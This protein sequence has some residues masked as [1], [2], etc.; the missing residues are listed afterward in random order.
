MSQLKKP[1]G[2]DVLTAARQRISLV[3]DR[4]E[5]VCVSFS[6]GKDST[7]LLHLT[8]DEAIRRKRRVGVLF[9]DLEAQYRATIEHAEACF[10]LYREHIDPYWVALPLSLRNA[11]SQYEPKWTCWD[12]E[13]RC[14][15]GAAAQADHRAGRD[16]RLPRVLGGL[17]DRRGD[18]GAGGDGLTGRCSVIRRSHRVQSRKVIHRNIALC[19]TI[20]L[21]MSHIVRYLILMNGGDGAASDQG[22]TR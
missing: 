20:S 17:G 3:F 11:V 10:S 9:I 18:A 14:G 6:A 12:P 4:F 22:E 21:A 13:R 5:R 15:R 16:V 1:L 7:V 19:A 8:M 2:I